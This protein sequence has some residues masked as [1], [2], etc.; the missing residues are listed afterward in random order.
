MKIITNTAAI[1]LLVL[2]FVPQLA[3]QE[4]EEDLI[5]M[6]NKQNEKMEQAMIDND[7][8]YFM[9]QYC[10]IIMSLPSYQEPVYGLDAVKEMMEEY[11][12]QMEVHSFKAKATDVISSENIRVEIGTYKINMTVPMMPEPIDDEGKYMNV[13]VKNADG[14]WKLAVETWNTDMNPW[15]PPPPP[16]EESDG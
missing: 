8:E 9:N 1:L 11:E 3:A 7:Y 12:P 14:E 16:T 5:A 6:F 2:L 13:W 10:K 15:M 4:S